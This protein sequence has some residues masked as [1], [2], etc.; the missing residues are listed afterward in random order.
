MRTKSPRLKALAI[1]RNAA[2]AHIHDTRSSVP[3]KL[4]PIGRVKAP[5]IITTK[6]AQT[7]K[8]PQ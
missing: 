5:P 6:M 4:I 8:A 7:K 1:G 2:A 3:L